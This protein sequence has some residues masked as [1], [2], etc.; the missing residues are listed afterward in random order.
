VPD[1]YESI[2]SLP[3]PALA[4]AL[5]LDLKRFKRRKEDWQGYC[6]VHN[7]KSNNNCFAYH[8]SGKFHCFSCGAKGSGAI[9]LCKL[10]KN[11]AFQAAVEIL[12][13]IPAQQPPKEKSPVISDSGASRNS[14]SATTSTLISSEP[15]QSEPK[16]LMK[17]TWRKFAIPC[18][19][20]QQRCPDAAVRERYGVFFYENNARKS[21][22]NGH[23]LI[24]IRD[25]DGVN[26]G[27][28]A[29]NIGEVTADR[30][31]Y[32]FPTNLP[33]SRFVFGGDQLHTFG[34]LPLRVVYLLES[35]LAV[36]KFASLGLPA[37]SNFGWAVSE[38][39]ATPLATL[40]KGCIYLPDRNKQ[41]ECDAVCRILSRKLW[42]RFPELPE[43]IHD[44]EE[45]D[46]ASILAF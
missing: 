9:D 38:E 18:P 4:S 21:A 15:G 1:V 29:R 36:M 13:E 6:P 27:Y 8:D 33:K 20:L 14:S 3:F 39:Q 30:P 19:W 44:P 28:Q 45:M 25:I 12:G 43:A 26:Y 2:R 16:P 32:R 22:V 7:S 46:K 23:V 40:A 24:P 35:P 11:V 42:L 34:S 5:G 41:A 10:V 17:D 37:V 31:R